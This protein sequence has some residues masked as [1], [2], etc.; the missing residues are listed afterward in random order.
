M[1]E[2]IGEVVGEAFDPVGA[3]GLSERPW[4]RQS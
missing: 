3:G 1:V 2:K 4:P